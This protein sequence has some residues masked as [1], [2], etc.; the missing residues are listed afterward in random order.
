MEH[1]KFVDEINQFYNRT[2]MKK[3]DL[4]KHLDMD[5]KT[6]YRWLTGREIACPSSMNHVRLFMRHYKPGRIKAKGQNVRRPKV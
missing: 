6:I 4:S 1:L 5:Y 2:G 3:T